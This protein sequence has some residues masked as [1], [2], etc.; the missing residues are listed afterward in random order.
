MAQ[1]FDDWE[2]LL[3]NDGSPDNTLDVICE[4]AR[5]DPR[6]KV[7]DQKNSGVSVA[8][9]RGIAEASGEWIV[10]L[11]HDDALM[12]GALVELQKRGLLEITD[13]LYQLPDPGNN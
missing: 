11:D 2:L 6:I 5:K 8:R 12:P 13:F 9:N 10:W 4:H 1:N 3:I 7:I